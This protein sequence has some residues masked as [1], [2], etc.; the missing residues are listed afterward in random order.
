MI[1]MKEPVRKFK[2][3]DLI[4]IPIRITIGPKSWQENKVEVKKRW[5]DE[6]ELV[7]RDLVLEVVKKIIALK[8]VIG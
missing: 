2:D 5:E 7:D 4:G 1:E 3:A 6:S 8:L